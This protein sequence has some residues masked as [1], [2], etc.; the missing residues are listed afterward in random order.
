[1]IVSVSTN[2]EGPSGLVQRSITSPTRRTAN[3]SSRPSSGYPTS[4]ATRRT[5]AWPRQSPPRAL[6]RTA[7]RTE[8]GFFGVRRPSLCCVGQLRG[9]AVP[10]GDFLA[11]HHHRPERIPRARHRLRDRHRALARRAHRLRP[12]L[13]GLDGVMGFGGH[14]PGDGTSGRGLESVVGE[15]GQRF[16][17][18]N[19]DDHRRIPEMSVSDFARD[20]P[21]RP[22]LRNVA[23]VDGSVREV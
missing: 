11:R 20:L 22:L 7:W 16:P 23:R 1:M 19:T 13:D 3:S 14:P 5:S 12:C 4:A 6:A 9:L 21:I 8:P 10:S 15:T 2:T 18:A 17:S